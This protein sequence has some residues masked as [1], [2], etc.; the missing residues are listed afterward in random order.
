MKGY[1]QY[2]LCKNIKKPEQ[3]L[4][5]GDKCNIWESTILEKPGQEQKKKSLDTQ[6]QLV[7]TIIWT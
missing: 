2:K 7:N 4:R 6:E 1:I 3:F 5:T